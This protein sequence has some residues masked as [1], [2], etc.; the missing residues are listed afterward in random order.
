MKTTKISNSILFFTLLQMSISFAFGQATNDRKLELVVRTGHSNTVEFVAFSPDGKLFV[1]TGL[2]DNIILWDLET[3]QEI[4]SLGKHA[5]IN[6]LIFSA[7]GK[8]LLGGSTKQ[9]LKIWDVQTGQEIRSFQPNTKSGGFSIALSPD[10]KLIAYVYNWDKQN[11]VKILDADTGNEI[12][13][14]GGHSKS[15]MQIAFSPDGKTLASLS[16]DNTVKIWDVKTG[17]ELESSA[18]AS[19]NIYEPIVFSSDGNTLAIGSFEQ[20]VYLM[21]TKSGQIVKKFTGKGETHIPLAFSENSKLLATI[22]DN[23]GDFPAVRFWDVESGVET[24]NIVM[25]CSCKEVAINKDFDTLAMSNDS[26]WDVEI[27]LI[28][29][30]T[31]KKIKSLISHSTQITTAGFLPNGKQIFWESECQG[32]KLWNLEQS[33]EIQILDDLVLSLHSTFISHDE[34][35]FV[36]GSDHQISIW[37]LK[38]G[39]KLRDFPY[40]DSDDYLDRVDSVAISPD[41]KLVAGGINKSSGGYSIRLWDAE[42]GKEL[43]PFADYQTE[44][45]GLIFSPDSKILAGRDFRK[46]I[47]LWNLADGQEIISKN[48]PDW[49]K[50]EDPKIIRQNGLTIKIETDEARIR[51]IN[52]ETKQIIATLFAIDDKDW[53]VV[54]PDGRF[55]ASE[56]ALKFMHYAYGLEVIK[57]DQL[58]EAYYEP[59]LLQKLLGFNKESL[60]PI[61][62]LENVRLFPE[63]LEQKFDEKTETLTFKLKNRGGGIGETRILVN[64][65]LAVADARDE[66]LK[67]NPLVPDDSV[68]TLTADLKGASVL[69]GRENKIE[70]ITSNY[71][72]EIGKGNI[73][74]RGVETFYQD[75]GKEEFSLPTLYAIVGGV[76]DYEGDAIDL[77]F[78]AKD[79][80]DFSNALSLGAKRLFC[81]KSKPDC[82]DKVQ[83]TTLSTSGKPGTIQPTK[84]N[85]KKAFADIAKKARPEDI[86]VIYLAG[87]G[88]SFGTGTDTY[89]Y[90]TKDARSASKEDLTKVYQTVAISST[91]LTEWLTTE[92]W[93]EGEKGIKALKQVLILDT[94]ASGTAA[95]ALT[96]K[97]DLSGDQ[98]RA[99]EFLKDKTG[100]FVLMGSTADA[101]SY[102]ASQF[103]QGLLT[104]SLLQAMKG[105]ELDKGEFIDV[106]K[107]FTYAEQEVP[108]MA[109]NIGGLQRPI[110]SAPLGKTFVI[111]QMTESD[112]QKISLPTPK[113][114][115]LRPLLTKPPINNDPLKLIPELRKRLD[116]ESSYE[117]VRQRGGQ[118]PILIYIDDDS[119]P[120]AV[121]VTGT[122]TFEGDQIRLKAYLVKGEEV[123]AELPEI[124]GTKEE[125]LNKLIEQIRR[126]LATK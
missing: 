6:K 94:C 16:D 82:P 81:D 31:N 85:F 48:I 125:V 113:P 121:R 105:A 73:Q 75:S 21:D 96:A 53:A 117:V 106:R 7:D 126:G 56:G 87:H 88:V 59:G 77:R 65:K 95:A 17:K 116:A 101:P 61:I 2:D 40:S 44:I 100:T 122:Y 47:R 32:V 52:L 112:K 18:F 30:E 49:V 9:I 20:N 42:S 79:A 68:V 111:G 1:S 99:I 54:A 69:K 3:G 114:L 58:K 104:Y 25:E 37:D 28:D 55:D 63:I 123:L 93:T 45:S 35:V 86:I 115:M 92:E 62:P 51:L 8:I 76:S 41:K 102:E 67:K 80:E 64:G 72:K 124:E 46:N 38:T 71:L 78:A 22:D 98:I 50:F 23:A 60:R 5:G 107:L 110:V 24:K 83:I 43:K 84:E 90:L 26:S 29:I 14:L 66:N 57:L 103:G 89:F 19:P 11:S 108:K 10:K 91:E 109:I 118:E 74:S 13:T 15:V 36:G 70:V 4:K 27:D 34:K 12:K 33:D 97:R 39:K 120:E 119:F